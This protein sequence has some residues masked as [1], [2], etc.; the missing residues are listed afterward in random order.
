MPTLTREDLQRRLKG[1]TAAQLDSLYLLH[2]AEDFLRDRAAAAI[3]DVALKGASLR[4]FNDAS[5][6]LTQTDVQHALGV[7]EQLPMMAERRVVCITNFAKLREEQD[8]AL[9]RYVAKPSPTTTVIF[10]ADEL[11]KRK[12]LSKALL[13]SCTSIEFAALGD[14][15]LRAW[16]RS[17]LKRDLTA[18]ADERVLGHVIALTGS[19]VRRLGNELSKLATAALPGKQITMESVE[20][21]V[22]RSREHTN[23]E[24]SDQMLAG[25]REKALHTLRLLFED[26]AEPLMLLG[27]IAKPVSPPFACE[28]PHGGRRA[29]RSG[30]AHARLTLQQTRRF[31]R[32]RAPRGRTRTDTRHRA[33]QRRRPRHQK[34]AR[35]WRRGRGAPA[36]RSSRLRTYEIVK[37]GSAVKQLHCA[38]PHWICFDFLTS[39][40]VTDFVPVGWQGR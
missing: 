30:G 25:N 13:D 10:L 36:N 32:H 9:M 11:D 17:F 6:D 40:Y 28:K 7:A 18:E 2:G 35:R 33:P 29:Q 34:L 27:L 37:R 39:N 23:F 5:F 19:S 31:P 12:R 15:E 1:A 21:L 8:E 16:A 14:T 4:E 3:T 24:L 20:A 22:G 38:S 26:G